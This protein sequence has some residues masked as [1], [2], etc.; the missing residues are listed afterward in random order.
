[1]PQCYFALAGLAAEVIKI[2]LPKSSLG[3][4]ELIKTSKSLDY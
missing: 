1:M 2:Q 4:L 3:H